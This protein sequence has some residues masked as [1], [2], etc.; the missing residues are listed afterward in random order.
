MH[1]YSYLGSTH[2]LFIDR[3]LPDNAFLIPRW[4][5]V[6]IKNLPKAEDGHYRLDKKKLHSTMRI[7]VSQ[8]RNLIGIHEHDS[9]EVGSY[10]YT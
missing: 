4:G 10:L 8:L 6:L 5:G 1:C 9:I 2:S 3:P 7:F